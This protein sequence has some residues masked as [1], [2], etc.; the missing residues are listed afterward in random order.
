[1]T[2]SDISSISISAAEATITKNNALDRMPDSFCSTATANTTTTPTRA[3][4]CVAFDLEPQVVEIPALSE[5]SA[6]ERESTWY[7]PE[8][9]SSMIEQ[10]ML[11]A[12]NE[13]VSCV[14]GFFY[15]GRRTSTEDNQED[16]A[17]GLEFYSV[18][19]SRRRKLNRIKVVIAVLKEQQRQ[20]QEQQEEQQEESPIQ[21]GGDE[22]IEA[23]S[24]ALSRER[25]EE[26]YIQGCRD[27]EAVFPQK[28][29]SLAHHKTDA[30]KTKRRGMFSCFTQLVKDISDI[31]YVEWVA[32]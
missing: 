21:R 7:T 29:R 16:C 3:L 15:G 32:Q 19:G 30:V 8:E 27:E 4:H 13:T 6:E 23:V 12:N 26:A 18:E 9:K 28:P 22:L 11:L 2:S 25:Q 14:G 17:R 1:M 20:Q 5:L 10:A 24:S 31:G